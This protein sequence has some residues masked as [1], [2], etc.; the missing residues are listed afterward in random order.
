M[1]M[2][3]NKQLA[4]CGFAP[5]ESD[6]T[7]LHA[8]GVRVQIRDVG[9]PLVT[10]L[11]PAQPW[12]AGPLPLDTPEDLSSFCWSHGLITPF[13]A[14][15]D[16]LAPWPA[17]PIRD[18]CYRDGRNIRARTAVGNA[19]LSGQGQQVCAHLNGLPWPEDPF[20][21]RHGHP[22]W[23]TPGG[24]LCVHTILGGFSGEMSGTVM[25]TR[26]TR[27]VGVDFGDDDVSGEVWLYA[28]GRGAVRVSD[29]GGVAGLFDPVPTPQEAHP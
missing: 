17:M 26:G 4:A 22:G 10:I 8:C 15:R 24:V 21:G 1:R 5:T 6:G 11:N 2:N 25:L 7:A 20:E 18:V 9:G 27:H 19:T 13:E 29:A 14:V 16:A 28:A 12:M 23:R 3:L